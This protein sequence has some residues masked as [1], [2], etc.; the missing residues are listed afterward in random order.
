MGVEPLSGIVV[1]AMWERLF[2]AHFLTEVERQ[3]V[4]DTING[5]LTLSQTVYDL[6]LG[7]RDN[8]ISTLAFSFRE[9]MIG[10]LE[11][12]NRERL[13]ATLRGQKQSFPELFNNPQLSPEER[14]RLTGVLDHQLQTKLDIILDPD[15]SKMFLRTIRQTGFP[16]HFNVVDF[17]E[18]EDNIICH[19][20][21]SLLHYFTENSEGSSIDEKYNTHL[22]MFQVSKR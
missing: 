8:E 4:L 20:L 15:Q 10:A 1:R 9:L 14:G 21:E 16:S 7:S 3:F 13:L 17:I 18:D 11:Q 2:D 19:D 5:Q 22:K 12:R 6:V